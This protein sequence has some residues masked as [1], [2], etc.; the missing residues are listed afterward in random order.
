MRRY[1]IDLHEIECGWTAS[2]SEPGIGG[3]FEFGRTIEECVARIPNGVAFVE[4]ERAA[5]SRRKAMTVVK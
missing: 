2:Y 5:R 4:K 3:F 1:M